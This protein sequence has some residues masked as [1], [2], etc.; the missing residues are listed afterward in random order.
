MSSINPNNNLREIIQKYLSGDITVKERA[1]LDNYYAYFE[2]NKEVLDQLS[3]EE[4][5]RLDAEMWKIVKQRTR[6]HNISRP[7][8]RWYMVAAAAVLVL[9]VVSV[10]L[11]SPTKKTEIVTAKNTENDKNPAVSSAQLILADGSVINLDSSYGGALP[12][13]GEVELAIRDGRLEYSGSNQKVVFNTM[14]TPKGGNYQLTLSDHTKVW[15]NAAS[16]IKFPASFTENKREVF[17]SGEA[18]FEVAKDMKPF[19]VIVEGKEEV[20]VL[21]THF[22][23]NAYPDQQSTKTTL[24]EGKVKITQL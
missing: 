24:L 11:F 19:K 4:R 20:E 21:G 14:V 7:V 9:A 10:F 18:Y 23:I 17:L 15:L 8:H 16:T 2:K 22:N 13:Q 1:F 5:E 6:H 12:N 3:I